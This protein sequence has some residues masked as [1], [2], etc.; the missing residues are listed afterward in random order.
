MNLDNVVADKAHVDVTFGGEV[1]RIVYRP[2]FLTID[3][4]NKL[5]GSDSQTDEFLGLIADLVVSWDVKS[6]GKKVPVNKANLA[7][8]PILFL[9]KIVASVVQSAGETDQG[10]A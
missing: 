3:T 9:K 10:E 2:A 8:M 4:I 5:Y 7:T 6:K 1:A